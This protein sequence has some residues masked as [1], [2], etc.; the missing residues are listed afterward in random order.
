MYIDLVFGINL[1][2]DYLLLTMMQKLA[3]KNS[4]RGRKVIAA[5][6]GGLGACI[7]IAIP[8]FRSGVIMIIFSVILAGGMLK[9]A[10]RYD[11][12]RALAK[13][14]V[15]YYAITFL[16]GGILNY[17]YYY[18]NAG[19][20]ITE[21]VRTLP[22]RS[23]NFIYLMC[24]FGFSAGFIQLVK[25]LLIQMKG[26]RELFYNVELVFDGKRLN[27]KGLLDTGNQLREPISRKPVVIADFES[28]KAILPEELQSYSKD[29]VSSAKHKDIDRYALKIKW[30]PYHAVG[31][32]EGILPG[33]VFDEINIIREQGIS[34]NLNI[35]V[36]IYQGKLTVDNSYHIILH[37]ELL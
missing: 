15:I 8:N 1:I 32:D 3:K 2:M 5:I 34:K 27:C 18:T 4:V 20:Y 24:L 33:I 30:I 17:I 29:F 25:K 10:F 36:A 19:Y 6:L 35:T 28:I 12:I 31:T 26:T 11:T 9:I 21:F 7:S 23:I 16:V 14:I 22:S 37:Q 13:D